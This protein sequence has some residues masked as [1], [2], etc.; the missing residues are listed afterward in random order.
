MTQLQIIREKKGITQ[1][2]LARRVKV[3][4]STVWQ[5][6]QRGIKTIRTAKKYAQVLECNPRDLLD[7]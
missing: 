7:I 5:T 6:E 4:R 1:A 2:E 3:A